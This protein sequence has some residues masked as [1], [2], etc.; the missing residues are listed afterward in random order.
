MISYCVRSNNNQQHFK[1]CK[2]TCWKCEVLSPQICFV[3]SI[4]SV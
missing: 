2:N 4:M 1:G 3:L